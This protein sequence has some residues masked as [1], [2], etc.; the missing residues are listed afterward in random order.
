MIHGILGD[1]KLLRRQATNLLFSKKI[2]NVLSESMC[3]RAI[4][5]PKGSAPNTGMKIT[6]KTY[7]ENTVS[8]FFLKVVTK[9]P[10]FFLLYP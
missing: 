8:Y 6:G 10:I 5:M 9:C 3:Y 7:S 4:N 1:L 2:R